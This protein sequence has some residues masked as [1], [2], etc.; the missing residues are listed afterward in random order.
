[1]ALALL[2]AAPAT[3][4]AA[5]GD[6]DPAFS[7]DGI[8]V[9]G[10]RGVDETAAAVAVQADGKVVVAGSA[11]DRFLV[12]RYTAAGALDSTF[13]GDGLQT[14]AAADAARAVAIQP[15]GKIVAAGDAGAGV[16]VA[17][18]N[19][20]GSFDPSFSG[21]GL[22]SSLDHGVRGD[23]SAL[24]L[25]PDGKI[26]I[27]GSVGG[28]PAVLRYHAD[29][30]PDASFSAD[31][32]AALERGI[33]AVAALPGTGGGL[34]VAAR[35][36]TSDISGSV[37]TTNYLA[38]LNAD[39][40]PAGDLVTFTTS[41]GV[42]AAALRPDGRVVLAADNLVQY[43]ADG[44]RDPAFGTGGS[45]FAAADAIALDADGRLVAASAGEDGPTI[46]RRDPA[47]ELD[48]T[49]S[50]DGER[51][52][53]ID[54]AFEDVTVA[55]DGRIVAVGATGG[56]IVVARLLA[57]GDPLPPPEAGDTVNVAADGGVL[58]VRPPGE[59]RFRRVRAAEQ[60]PVG[61]AVDV[62]KGRV[63]LTTATGASGRVQTASF[64]GGT[65]R[66]AQPDG[67]RPVTELRLDR[68]TGCGARAS[69]AQQR[70]RKRKKTNALWGS[71]TGRF[72]TRGRYGSA[73]VRGTEW[74]TR[75]Q[76]SGT[77]IRVREG[78]VAVRDFARGRTV[79]L[80][81]PR[82]YLARARG[83]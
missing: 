13:S 10:E 70:K 18:F 67:R 47:G 34:V 30:A 17:R 42:R 16:A 53:G 21:D 8:A 29:G 78:R 15:D 32:V 11:G 54:G 68:V 64:Y 71:G 40:T 28:R 83:R 35:G 81:A 63:S 77:Y 4:A 37:F 20:D 52:V 27:A 5:P 2:L 61:T 50:Q 7:G 41:S 62:T 24:A 80:R 14:V 75:E 31:G 65:F 82:S 60:L 43:A 79:Q 73:A 36:G 51:A 6:L 56:D 38:R 3:A 57:A 59:Q 66:I 46:T 49:F 22:L 76:C 19:A 58:R 69:I 48:A 55:P 72:V 25:Q 12:V 23:A 45:V 26:L 9:T 44:T 1:M 74:L 39:G 33:A